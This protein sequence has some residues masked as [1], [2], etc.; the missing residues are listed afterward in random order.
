M[1]KMI[2][3]DLNEMG[4]LVGDDVSLR[5]PSLY[6]GHCP[7]LMSYCVPDISIPRCPFRGNSREIYVCG[8]PDLIH[9][10]KSQRLSLRLRVYIY[11]SP[12]CI[13]LKN[14]IWNCATTAVSNHIGKGFTSTHWGWDKIVD[15]SQ[16]TFKV[17][18]LK[19]KYMNFDWC[20]TKVYY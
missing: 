4:F 3:G 1:P 13:H 15:I 9:L 16:T 14:V 17:N 5:S 11:W 6:V 10:H 19:W 2:L 12:L 7:G 8:F 20:F 18:F